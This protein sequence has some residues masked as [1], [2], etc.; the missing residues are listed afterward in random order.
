MFIYL[1]PH[2]IV[3]NNINNDKNFIINQYPY[4]FHEEVEENVIEC[5]GE[6]DNMP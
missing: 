3:K 6:Y 2:K 5:D 1:L 4:L